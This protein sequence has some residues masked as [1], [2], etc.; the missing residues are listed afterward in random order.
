MSSGNEKHEVKMFMC[1]I[2]EVPLSECV[3]HICPK[4]EIVEPTLCKIMIFGQGGM[5]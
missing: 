4:T 1:V 2:C 5:C 3:A